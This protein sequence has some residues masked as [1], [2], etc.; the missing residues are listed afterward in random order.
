MRRF[1]IA[2]V[3]I[4]GTMTSTAEGDT[5]SFRLQLAPE[6]VKAGLGRYLLVRFALKTG[7]HAVLVAKGKAADI[8]V[9]AAPEAQKSTPKG[10]PVMTR[11][12]RV[13]VLQ[14]KGDNP[15]AARF[16]DWL[17][18]KIG[19]RMIAS[20]KPASGAPFV[21]AAEQKA[22]GEITFEGNASKGA[23]LAR[24]YCARC[25]RVAKGAGMTLGTTPSFMVLR[26]LPD[27][28]D[29]MASYYLRNPHPSF[30]RIKGVSAAFSKASPPSLVPIILTQEEVTAIQAYVS[31]LKPADLGA[32]LSTK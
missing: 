7:R 16:S 6:I 8:S 5:R 19:Q 20:F 26:A 30:M 14:Q 12:G 15:A 13:F 23:R 11:N 32:P 3:L 18:S 9:L 1:I 10:R 27:W 22:A 28:A 4:A 25:H 17:L 2:L 31:A 21:G 24:R 29:R